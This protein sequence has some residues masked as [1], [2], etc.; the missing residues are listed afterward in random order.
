M[1]QTRELPTGRGRIS[2]GMHPLSQ[3]WPALPGHR[4]ADRA[5]I[6]LNAQGP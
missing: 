5:V 6:M 2:D 3:H 4:R 1:M